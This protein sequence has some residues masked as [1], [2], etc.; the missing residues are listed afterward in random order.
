MRI[1]RKRP[2]K[3]IIFYYPATTFSHFLHL[4]P[5]F[6]C[7]KWACSRKKAYICHT[8]NDITDY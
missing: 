8:T 5:R 7:D 1:A 2:A 6:S 3:L 4:N